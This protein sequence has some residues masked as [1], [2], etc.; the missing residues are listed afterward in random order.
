MQILIPRFSDDIDTLSRAMKATG[1]SLED[2]DSIDIVLYRVTISVK[3]D[4]A[5]FESVS[6]RKGILNNKWRRVRNGV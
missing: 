2:V 3:V 4:A 6:L 5:D 1:P